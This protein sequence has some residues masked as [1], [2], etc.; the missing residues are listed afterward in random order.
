MSS[1]RSMN[2]FLESK[3]SK[4]YNKRLLYDALSN[5]STFL[6]HSILCWEI[7][8]MLSEALKK[9]SENR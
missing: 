4:K 6:G 9:I 7:F 8:G 1:S 5:G 2:N 3:I